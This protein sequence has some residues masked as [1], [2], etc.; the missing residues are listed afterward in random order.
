MEWNKE[1]PEQCK[2]VVALDAVVGKWKPLIL[3]HLLSKGTLR[4]NEIKRLI[5]DVTQ[6]VLTLHLRQLEEQGIVKRVVYR[7]VPPKVEYSLTE[8]GQ[9]LKPVLEA[10]HAWGLSHLEHLENFKN[11]QSE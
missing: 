1:N 2:V 4:Y 3:L 6:R 10:M 8:H 9:T 11:T 5:P 7:Q